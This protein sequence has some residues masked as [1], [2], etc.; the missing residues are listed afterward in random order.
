M[1]ATES[2]FQ[3]RFTQA[4]GRPPGGSVLAVAFAGRD[5]LI[6][7]QTRLAEGTDSGLLPTLTHELTHLALGEVERQRGAR[8]PGG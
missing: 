4:A 5:L 1:A 3:R 2:E 7:R 6:V 8:L